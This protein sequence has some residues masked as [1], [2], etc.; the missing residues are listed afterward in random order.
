[1]LK[2]VAILLVGAIGLG[3]AEYAILRWAAPI[4]V[5]GSGPMPSVYWGHPP[6][7]T[8]AE[9]RDNPEFQ[10][11]FLRPYKIVATLLALIGGVL[12]PV[13]IRAFSKTSSVFRANAATC[14]VVLLAISAVHDVIARAR[15]FEGMPIILSLGSLQVFAAA[16]IPAALLS[17]AIAV[18]LYRVR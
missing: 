5:D 15:M 3:L 17:G 13:S 10:R 7:P 18:A 6:T 8:F 4:Y 9:W 2:V 11:L 1:M 14:F 16:A 12:V